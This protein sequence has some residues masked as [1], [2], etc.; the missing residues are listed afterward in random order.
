MVNGVTS[1]AAQSIAASSDL[2]KIKSEKNEDEKFLFNSSVDEVPNTSKN[3]ENKAVD[4]D[5]GLSLVGK[6]FTDKLKEIGTAIVEHPGKT[7]AAVILTTAAIA[8]APLVGIASATVAGG[9]A[10]GFGGYALGK[11][12]LDAYDAY[13]NNKEGNYDKVRENLQEIGGD[14]L[15]LAASLPFVPK[16]LNQVTRQAKFGTSTIGL[17]KE[18]VTD[19]ISGIDKSVENI[20][21]SIG[22]KIPEKF[23]DKLP[24]K[25]SDILKNTQ[26]ETKGGVLYELKKADTKVNYN[27]IANETGLKVKPELEITELPSQR[28][29]FGGENIQVGGYDN[30][31]GK[32][33][34]NEKVLDKNIKNP[35]LILRHELEHFRQT[36]DIARTYGS[37]VLKE[38]EKGR[39]TEAFLKGGGSLEKT[40]YTILDNE[41]KNLDEQIYDANKTGNTELGQSA[42]MRKENTITDFY[43]EIEKRNNKNEAALNNFGNLKKQAENMIL[44]DGSAFNSQIY[45]DVIAN[46]GTIKYGTPEAEKA[47]EYLDGL[48]AKI[49]DADKVAEQINNG[50]KT[51]YNENIIEQEAVE[52]EQ[53]YQKEV[54]DMRPSTLTDDAAALTVVEDTFEEDDK[55]IVD[56]VKEAGETIIDNIA[57]PNFGIAA[58]ASSSGSFVEGIADKVKDFFTND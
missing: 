24:D 3:S 45:E 17:N 57:N 22:Q 35:E 39:Y 43:K 14:G 55:N 32:I 19:V 52:A 38:F 20:K 48:T 58:T 13:K 27:M 23:I 47:A 12:A 50:N 54:L 5:E 6:G 29:L 56:V 1:L 44:G 36:S 41:L 46:K 30:T 51:L 26:Q 31:S 28:N 9:L 18:A 25:L 53:T 16:G 21:N 33:F 4:F 49:T 10:L 8:A 37:E 11:T 2:N 42:L 15:E 34:L 7:A 40:D